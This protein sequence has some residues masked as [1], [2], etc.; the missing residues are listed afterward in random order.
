MQLPAGYNDLDYPDYLLYALCILVLR[1]NAAETPAPVGKAV[2][3]SIAAKACCYEGLGI[4]IRYKSCVRHDRELGEGV[5]RGTL[6]HPEVPCD[7]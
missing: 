4:S 7:A 3:Y 6:S 5:I 1:D 2:V